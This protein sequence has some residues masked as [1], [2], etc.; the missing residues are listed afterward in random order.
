ML[1][2]PEYFCIFYDVIRIIFMFSLVLH[3]FLLFINSFIITIIYFFY[4]HK[5]KLIKIIK[6][7]FIYRFNSL[8]RTPWILR[9]SSKRRRPSLSIRPH[10]LILE[11][12]IPVLYIALVAH[13]S[14]S[15]RQ[16]YAESSFPPLPCLGLDASALDRLSNRRAW[17][18]WH[19]SVLYHRSYLPQNQ[20]SRQES[21]W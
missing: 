12:Q 17:S 1:I 14:S 8:V 18:P 10:L 9:F 19:A 5:V 16:S 21:P 4:I 13:H 20:S 11:S 2:Y 6:Y 3:H 7:F 15:S